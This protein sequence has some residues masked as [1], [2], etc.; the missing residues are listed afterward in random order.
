MA[1]DLHVVAAVAKSQQLTS[2]PVS[3]DS[4]RRHPQFPS[5]LRGCH[6]VSVVHSRRPRLFPPKLAASFTV[7]G[8]PSLLAVQCRELPSKARRRHCS[9]QSPLAAAVGSVVRQV[10][11]PCSILGIAPPRSPVC[12][13]RLVKSQISTATVVCWNSSRRVVVAAVESVVPPNCEQLLVFEDLW[14]GEERD[15]EKEP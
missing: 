1:L 15:Y 5:L 4:H 2:S 14:S 7:V 13:P 9:P 8:P 10:H 3:L 12:L 11:R 6:G